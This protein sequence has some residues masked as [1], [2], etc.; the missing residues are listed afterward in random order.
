LGKGEIDCHEA[1]PNEE[2]IG[3]ICESN[4]RERTNQRTLR[5]IVIRYYREGGCRAKRGM[6]RFFTTESTEDT[7]G[8]AE[9]GIGWAREAGAN[10]SKDTEG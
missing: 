5:G 9:V 6:R 8:E 2:Q 10:E 3:E 1:A 4:E 7:E